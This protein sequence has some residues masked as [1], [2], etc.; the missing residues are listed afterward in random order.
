M[1]AVEV[2]H[3]EQAFLAYVQGGGQVE[4]TDWLT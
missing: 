4:T 2:P 1:A 3:D